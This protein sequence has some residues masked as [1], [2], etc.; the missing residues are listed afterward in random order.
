MAR[1]RK[2]DL[3]K[4]PELL[5]KAVTL[6]DRELDSLADKPQLSTDESKTLINYVQTLSALY[7]DYRQEVIQIKK[8]LKEMPKDELMTL[9]KAEAS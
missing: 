4:I 6:M 7:K 2:I 8:E 5:Q 9:I 3:E 1:K